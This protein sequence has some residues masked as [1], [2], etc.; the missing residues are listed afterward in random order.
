MFQLYIP[1]GC[2]H[3]PPKISQPIPGGML[4]TGLSTAVARTAT[5]VGFGEEYRLHRQ[6]KNLCC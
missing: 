5:T 1:V 2:F 3:V 6:G 4:I